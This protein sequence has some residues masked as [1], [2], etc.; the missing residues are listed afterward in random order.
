MERLEGEGYTFI[1][2]GSAAI[3]AMGDK[4][5]SKRLA[6]EA[7]VNVIPGYDEVVPDAEEAVRISREIGSVYRSIILSYLH[8]LTRLCV[9][10]SSDDQ[11]QCRWRW[12]GASHRVDR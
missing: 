9:Q 10:V 12:Q 11:G 4:I 5:E 8:L 7:G 6:K 2:P 1:G 3:T